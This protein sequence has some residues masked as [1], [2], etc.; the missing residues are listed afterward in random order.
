MEVP[1]SAP[2]RARTGCPVE[3][4]VSCF[5]SPLRVGNTTRRYVPGVPSHRDTRSFGKRDLGSAVPA[6]R[7]NDGALRQKRPSCAPPSSR[8]RNT[9]LRP[10]AA[11]GVVGRVWRR[12]AVPL[13][14][15]VGR[16]PEALDRSADR[17]VH[18]VVDG[19]GALIEGRDRGH[20]DGSC[21]SN[22][23]HL[24]KMTDV[25]RGLAD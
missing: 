12:R 7:H 24:P 6:G 1:G 15:Q 22:R 14:D 3:S 4:L 16:Q 21:L 25:K 5:G 2:E 11:G 9:R 19:A 23:Y 17:V 10:S 20:H 18:E 13:A 8:S